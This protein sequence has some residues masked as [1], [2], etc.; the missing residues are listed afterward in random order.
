MEEKY[1]FKVIQS[2]QTK[3]V[4]V[5]KSGGGGQLIGVQR[6]TISYGRLGCLS[7]KDQGGGR[8]CKRLVGLPKEACRLRSSAVNC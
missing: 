2:G 1:S 5:V 7:G 6:C 4:R 8:F 3:L